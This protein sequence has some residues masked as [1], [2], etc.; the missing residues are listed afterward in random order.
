MNEHV[1]ILQDLAKHGADFGVEIVENPFGGFDYV[2]ER[3]E[4]GYIARG[5]RVSFA[6]DA[7]ES[8]NLIKIRDG[9]TVSTTTVTGGDFVAVGGYLFEFYRS[10]K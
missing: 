1:A 4:A 9:R 6:A 2:E 10:S 3:T 8:L 7:I 5:V